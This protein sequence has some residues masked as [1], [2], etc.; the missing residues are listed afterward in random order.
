MFSIIFPGQGSQSPGMCKDFYLKYDLIKQDVQG[1]EI[2]VMQGSP[3]IFR[4]AKYV[5]QEVNL[6]KDDDFPDM[7]CEL[8]M[9]DYMNELGFD[10]NLI[11]DRKDNAGQVDKIYF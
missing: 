11:I 7:P 8:E 6:D 9:D 5:I 2:M 10:N 4:R 1:A 3:D